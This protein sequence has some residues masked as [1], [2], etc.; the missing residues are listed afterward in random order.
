[1]KMRQFHFRAGLTALAAV[2]VAGA[3]LAQPK[4]VWE[5]S[6]FDQPESAVYDSERDVLY[7][8]NVHGDPGEK[9][10]DGY[11]SK[12]SLDGEVVEAQWV[13]G[14]DAPLGMDIHESTLYVADI[15][16]IVAIDVESGEITGTYPAE[17]AQFL[18]DV[19]A[20]EQGRVFVSDMM[21]NRIYVLEDGEVQVWVESED[22]ESPN[23]LYAEG[24]RIVVGA[25]G[26]MTDGFETEVPGHLKVVDFETQE[27]Q[28]LGDGTPVG[29][30][31][32]VEP[33]GEGNYLVTDWMA[34]K[35]YR[36]TPEGAAEELVDL[37]QGAAD[38]EYIEEQRLVVIPMMNDGVVVAYE[39]E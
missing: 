21:G 13:T 22:L 20:D 19:T 34:G 28:S 25:W 2:V 35:L 36:I 37:G 17:G 7:V 5:A 29:N 15:D 38:H 14:L 33:D 39:L 4:Q 6:G 1:M 3:A 11:V 30:L 8:S 32:G 31:D 9:T 16:R 10:R 18:N 24:D 26:V 27:V 12:L 23:G